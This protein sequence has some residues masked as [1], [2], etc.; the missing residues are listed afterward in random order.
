MIKVPENRQEDFCVKVGATAPFVVPRG[1]F[2]KRGV[3]GFTQTFTRLCSGGFLENPRLWR[4][5]SGS[6]IAENM[7]KVPENGQEG[8]C[9]KVGARAPFAVLRS[10]FPKR[11]VHGFAQT[12][13]RLCFCGFLGRPR[14]WRISS[15]SM[16]AEY[17]YKVPENGQEGV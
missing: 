14:L 13:S 6:M 8:V 10:S 3:H 4:F 2:P 7:I 15:G 9:V 17:K 1:S 5:R 12:F 11:G 16:Q